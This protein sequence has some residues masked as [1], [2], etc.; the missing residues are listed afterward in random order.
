MSD[1]LSITPGA[2]ET[3]AAE[4]DTTAAMPPILVI[5][6]NT[7]GHYVVLVA[8]TGEITPRFQAVICVEANDE[9]QAKRLA[10]GDKVDPANTHVASWLREMA[11]ETP[12]L[13]RAVPARNWPLEVKP[14]TF[15]VPEPILSI[16]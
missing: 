5:P 4:V 14:T 7:T 10:M 9:R 11:Q 8:I 12:I 16:G 13:L 3:A 2:A 1:T 15:V 6:E